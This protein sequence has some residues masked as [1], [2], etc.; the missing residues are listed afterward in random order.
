MGQ[1]SSHMDQANVEE[2]WKRVGTAVLGMQRDAATGLPDTNQWG[3]LNSSFHSVMDEASPC[4][5]P[6][7][8][9]DSQRI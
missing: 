4:G 2:L 8:V 7:S 9:P 6:H 5:F 3:V 1:K